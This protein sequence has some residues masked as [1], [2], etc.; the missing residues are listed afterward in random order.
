MSDNMIPAYDKA[1]GKKRRIP[2]HWL[3]VFPGK[4]RKT[5]LSEKQQKEADARKVDADAVEAAAAADAQA[6]L[7][8]NRVGVLPQ[9]PGA[10][11]EG[12]STPTDSNTG[13]NTNPPA[14]GATTE[15]A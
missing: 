5:P 8:A 2:P 3:D 10:V 15:G 12:T 14:T 13:D 1:T 6:R 7:A 9:V 11:G 4:F